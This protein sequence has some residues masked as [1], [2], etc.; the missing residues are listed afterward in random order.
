MLPLYDGVTGEA[1]PQ[2]MDNRVEKL[3]DALMDDARERV[4][5]LGEDLVVGV[6]HCMPCHFMLRVFTY[7][8]VFGGC[9]Q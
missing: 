4:D 7:A 3:R 8:D 1:V 2:H 6:R 5:N 9:D